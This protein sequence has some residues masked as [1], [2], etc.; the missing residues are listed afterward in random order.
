MTLDRAETIAAR[1]FARFGLEGWTI[2]WEDD[3]RYLGSCHS[4]RR[5]IYLSARHASRAPDDEVL[6]T[7]LHEIAHALSPEGVVHGPAWRT[8][9]REII[10]LV[11][12]FD[13]T[14]ETARC[15]HERLS[16]RPTHTT[17][18]ATCFDCGARIKVVGFDATKER[19]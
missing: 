3:A 18:L 12:G 13:A 17:C 10:D 16:S 8:K 11:V 14:K 5:T 19:S 7:I 1:L 6:A 4:S 15:R 9:L 2:T